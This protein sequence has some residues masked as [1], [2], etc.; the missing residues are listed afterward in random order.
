MTK[1]NI[2]IAGSSGRMGRA[3]VEAVLQAEDLRLHAAL[4]ISGSPYLKKMRANFAACRVK[5]LSP[6]MFPVRSKGPMYS[7]ISPGPK[8]R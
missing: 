1:L 3:L 6:M 5:Y 2:A 8:A 4:D 7:L